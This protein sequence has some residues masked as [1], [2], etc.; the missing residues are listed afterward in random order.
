MSDLDQQ[1]GTASGHS[2]PAHPASPT[3][4]GPLEQSGD[5]ESSP[6]RSPEPEETLPDAS[7]PEQGGADV[8]D[9]AEDSNCIESQQ[10]GTIEPSSVAPTEKPAKPK[11]KARPRSP[12]PP[13]PPQPAPITIRLDIPL[14]GPSNYAVNI[15]ECAK[16]AGQHPPTPPPRRRDSVSGSEDDDDDDEKSKG[17]QANDTASKLN[18]PVKPRRRRRRADPENEYYDLNDPF[19]DDSDLGVDAPT[20]FAQTKQKGFYVN[21]GDV[22]LVL[23]SESKLGRKR[24]AGSAST[25]SKLPSFL[26]AARPGFNSSRS[27]LHGLASK[28]ESALQPPDVLPFQLPEFPSRDSAA[29]A[30]DSSPQINRESTVISREPPRSV[31][32]GTQDS[33]I[34]L[35]DNDQPDAYSE[36][37]NASSKRM[38]MENGASVSISTL[39]TSNGTKTDHESQNGDL[40]SKKRKRSSTGD[41]L[42]EFSPLMQEEFRK[43]QP[44]VAKESFI[45]KNKFPPA[46]R[47]P[48]SE[49]ALKAV[50]L[51]E[52]GENF[53]KYITEIFPWNK[54]TMTKL[55]KRLI[56]DRHVK[57]INH[58]IDALLEELKIIVEEGFLAAQQAHK[59]EESENAPAEVA[60]N[61][62]DIGS[63]APAK[64]ERDTARPVQR[65]RW[66]DP[67]KS[68][69]WQMVSLN[70]TLA[71]MAN[72][73]HEYE[74]GNHPL[75]SDQSMRK[76][77]YQRIVGVF[78]EGWMTSGL[79]SR[80]TSNMKKKVQMAEQEEEVSD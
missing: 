78:P 9:V 48:L 64:R 77:L 36:T 58:R 41:L 33:P 7:H 44:L 65:Y 75:V 5:E 62:D 71:S 59:D 46:L 79:I 42:H 31:G 47:A 52:Y 55:V 26:T 66:T 57:I 80:E 73:M 34:A 2:T 39:Q 72:V 8:V 68:C 23:D 45:L 29:Q 10:E 49:V 53:F 70:N 6:S 30:D 15:L 74:P 37:M 20:H 25:T 69:V 56:Y 27:T 14:G 18:I 43:L 13:P 21:S 67:I 32:N 50:E 76:A 11:S 22:T 24:K 4:E 40:S 63:A 16:E 3:P 54:F 35:D 38:K 60:A 19:I 17:G 61:Q 51:D 28:P 1:E 12:T